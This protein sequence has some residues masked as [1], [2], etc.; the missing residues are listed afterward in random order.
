M[1]AVKSSPETPMLRFIST[2][3]PRTKVMVV[4]NS[5]QGLEKLGIV[6]EPFGAQAFV[7]R[8][9]PAMLG[10]LDYSA[11]V[12]DLVDD[13]AQ[14]SVPT[15]LDARVQPI[16]ATLA[17]HAAVRAG[18]PMELPEIKQLIEDWGAE[19]FPMTCPHGRRVALRLSMEELA[20]VFSRA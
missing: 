5:A 2:R 8:E 18:R 19:G 9:I 4:F 16:L 12:H 14:W 20:R 7:I 17:C 1:A 6:V 3:S 11:L 15:A 10:R 13:L